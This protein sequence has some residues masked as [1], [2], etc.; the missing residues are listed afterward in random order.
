MDNGQPHQNGQLLLAVQQELSL[1]S[2]VNSFHIAVD[3]YGS[4]VRL[5]GCV[6]SY[7]LKQMAQVTVMSLLRRINSEKELRNEIEVQ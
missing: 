2:H 1:S 3:Y 7:F 5:T 6:P 4:S